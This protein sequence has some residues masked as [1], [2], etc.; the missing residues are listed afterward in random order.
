MKNLILTFITILTMST[1]FAQ[2]G[3][4]IRVVLSDGN[5]HTFALGDIDSVY[6]VTEWTV[7]QTGPT[8][9]MIF[10][11]KGNYDNGWRY[12]EV[13][14]IDRPDSYMFGCSDIAFTQS[15]NQDFGFGDA[16]TI[17]IVGLCGSDNASYAINSYS[18]GNGWYL[19]S[20]IELQELLVLCVANPTYMTTLSIDSTAIY[21][22]STNDISVDN[23]TNAYAVNLNLDQSGISIN[24]STLGKAR[25]IR[26]F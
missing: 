6:Y 10:Y 18:G 5:I 14:T 15:I 3:P 9:G 16:N 17:S 11:D 7:G 22:S 26:K 12:L 13:D 4:A 21:W 2:T 19:P 24:R 25:P 23:T 20:I 8:G 1:M